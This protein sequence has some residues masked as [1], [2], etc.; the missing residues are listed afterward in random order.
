MKINI[1]D[2]HSF[3]TEYTIKSEIGDMDINRYCIEIEGILFAQKDD[4]R[5][6]NE[7]VKIGKFQ[8]FKLFL[9]E[10]KYSTFDIF[11]CRQEVRDFEEIFDFEEND[12]K[13]D[14]R[15]FYKDVVEG[16]NILILNRIEILPEFQ[17][18]GL[19]KSWMKQILLNFST[20]CGLVVAKSFPLQLENIE[21]EERSRRIMSDW[22]KKMGY[23]E[24]DKDVVKMKTSL[25][26]YH[27]S[28]GFQTIPKISEEL[29]FLNPAFIN[30]KMAEIEY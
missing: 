11:D 3:T 8:A 15:D 21:D 18:Y 4:S 10:E 2:N 27:K 25:M 13:S 23:L 9:I 1:H 26:K 14:I 20:D 7:K 29:I 30:K 17:G 22:G 5:D 12:F 28:M 24:K 19:S 6:E 16:C